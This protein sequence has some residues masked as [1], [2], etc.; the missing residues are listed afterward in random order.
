M[1]TRQGL[2][3]QL[4]ASD[5]SRLPATCNIGQEDRCEVLFDRL[6]CH[7]QLLP[8]QYRAAPVWRGT[9]DVIADDR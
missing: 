4:P 9:N 1:M 2:S 5:I 3:R 6:N 7:T 8:I